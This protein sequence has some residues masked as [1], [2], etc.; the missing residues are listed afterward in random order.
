MLAE[1]QRIGRKPLMLDVRNSYEWD[2]GHFEGAARPLEVRSAAA[3][4][5][6]AVSLHLSCPWLPAVHGVHRACLRYR[7]HPSSHLGTHGQGANECHLLT[8]LLPPCCTARC[9]ATAG[10][11]SRDSHGSPAHRGARLPGGEH[12]LCLLCQPTWR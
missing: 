3:A 5:A 2:A 11:L 9:T 4:A 6:P 7:R 8:V 12:L 1:G 10:Q